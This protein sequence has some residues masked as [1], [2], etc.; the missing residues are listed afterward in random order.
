[1]IFSFRFLFVAVSLMAAL[2]S[3]N[4][5]AQL[6]AG[7]TRMPPIIFFVAKGVPNSCGEGCDTWIAAHGE[8][9]AA[10]ASRLKRL[11]ARIGK[12]DLPIYFFS[13][14]GRVQEAMAIGRLMRERK[15]RAGVARTIPADCRD[16]FSDS[17]N[18]LRRADREVQSS[19]NTLSMCASACVYALL[20]APVREVSANA[21]LAVHA[22]KIV[23]MRNGSRI[24]VRGALVDYAQRRSR[25]YEAE[26]DRYTRSMGVDLELL[27]V[28]R[29]VPHESSRRLTR[30]E[31]FKFGIDKREFGD[32]GWIVQTTAS[33]TA[34]M[35]TVFR[36]GASG[37][38]FGLFRLAL[39]C[40]PS[41][42][43]EVSYDAQ[44]NGSNWLAGKPAL[45]FAGERVEL[46][47][48]IGAS[49]EATHRA[50][51]MVPRDVA[52]RLAKAERISFAHESDNAD[53]LQTPIGRAGLANAISEMLSRCGSEQARP[54][55]PD[56]EAALSDERPKYEA[57][58]FNEL[59]ASVRAAMSPN[60]GR[61]A[62]ADRSSSVRSVY[63][64][65]ARIALVNPVSVAQGV[66]GAEK[67]YS[68]RSV[69]VHKACASIRLVPSAREVALE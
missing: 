34:A 50:F 9:D 13:P 28:A 69:C 42:V 22:S 38:S 48:V 5:F 23:L 53:A 36:R 33:R 14:G 21:V 52:E 68:I 18:A 55:M 64:H 46:K 40:R 4:A 63:I 6:L 60:S 7:A 43:V 11:L 3:S 41:G 39:S 30:E 27:K 57:T 66:V 59:P 56:N 1:M 32:S 45:T 58:P 61:D 51:A 37:G 62:A 44:S 54:T 47:R 31:I 24:E 8:F 10:A 20:G 15:M 19:L 26:T 25:I 67:S 16:E 29:S 17:C 49:V 2:P 35:A 65:E 12:R